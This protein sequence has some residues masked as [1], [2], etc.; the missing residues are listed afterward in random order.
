MVNI[1]YICGAEQS[2]LSLNHKHSDLGDASLGHICGYANVALFCKTNEKASLSFV[3]T[4]NYPEYAEQG[5]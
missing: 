4:I 1:S 3:H 2:H 5:S